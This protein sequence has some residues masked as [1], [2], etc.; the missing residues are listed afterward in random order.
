MFLKNIDLKF[1][2]L[3]LRKRLIKDFKRRER[4]NGGCDRELG[5]WKI[6]DIHEIPE[7]FFE[8]YECD[9]YCCDGKDAYLL[10]LRNRLQEHYV[11]A[12]TKNSY[13][14]LIAELPI[15]TVDDALIEKAL[16][17]FTVDSKGRNEDG[18]NT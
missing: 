5:K 7:F 12:P 13:T 8:Q 1:K 18:R 11:V 4:F 17:K 6:I 9:F 15:T 16:E 3:L 10:R 2:R 14:Y